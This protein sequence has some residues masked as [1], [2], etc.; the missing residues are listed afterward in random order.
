M[1]YS[2][3]NSCF[4]KWYKVKMSDYEAEGE[5]FEADDCGYT[6]RS[7]DGDVMLGIRRSL[8]S[9]KPPPPKEVI[10]FCLCS[11]LCGGIFNRV[12]LC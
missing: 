11:D 7:S 1:K 4:L 12:T 10:M 5:D 6:W 8:R 3:T 9:R 2:L